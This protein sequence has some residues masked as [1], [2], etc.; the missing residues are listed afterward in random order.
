MYDIEKF[1]YEVLFNFMSHSIRNK[2][3]DF[4]EN[5]KVYF[6]DTKNFFRKI[7]RGLTSIVNGE[8]YF[9]KNLRKIVELAGY[10]TLNNSQQDLKNT[11]YGFK[12]TLRQLD[13]LKQNP[14]RF[15]ENKDALKLAI[16][17]EKLR[18]FYASNYQV[19]I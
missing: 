9:V 2:K 12:N 15:Y 10:N 6:D 1:E 11:I 17:C 3:T 7:V 13:S 16:L 19:L 4:S 14:K 18:D 8:P 5:S